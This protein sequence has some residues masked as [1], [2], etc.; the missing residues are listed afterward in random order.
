MKYV[1]ENGT[2]IDTE[3]LNILFSLL[4]M[5]TNAQYSAIKYHYDQYGWD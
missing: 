3:D 5:E 4:A 2:I 1:D